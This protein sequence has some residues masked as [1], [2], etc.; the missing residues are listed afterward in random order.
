MKK[1]RYVQIG[2]ILNLLFV[3]FHLSF[4]ELFDWP[5]TLAS[6]SLDNWAIMQ[7]LNIHTAYVLGIF[8]ILSLIFPEE[9]L[10]S[11]LGRL[12]GMGIAGFWVLRAVNQAVFWNIF[13]INAWIII[14]VC[15]IVALLYLGPMFARPRRE[16]RTIPPHL[17][18]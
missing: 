5:Q 4:W 11:R 3:I 15:L 9:L 1:K 13:S 8:A 6:L 10:T 17:I 14:G 12:M 7:V 18:K 2:G 16:I